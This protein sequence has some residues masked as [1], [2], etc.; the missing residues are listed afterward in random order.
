MAPIESLNFQVKLHKF[1]LNFLHCFNILIFQFPTEQHTELSRLNGISCTKFRSFSTVLPQTTWSGLST[2]TP[3]FWYQLVLVGVSV[4]A[5]KHCEQKA[6]RGG[7]GLFGLHVHIT[8]HPQRSE[9][10][11]SRRTG[12][13]RQEVMQRPW[14]GAAY[15][16]AHHD[17]LNLLSYIF[18]VSLASNG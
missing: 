8:V 4:A 12:T 2:A 7:K 18:I 16:L 3:R 1:A 5:M 9:D 13:W 11:Y 17:L 10:S 6:S 15:C 14:R